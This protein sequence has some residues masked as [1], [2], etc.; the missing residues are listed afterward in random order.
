MIVYVKEYLKKHHSHECQAERM[1]CSILN[2]GRSYSS[3]YKK[4]LIYSAKFKA[5]TTRE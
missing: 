2:I 5:H 4:I 3:T 1:C